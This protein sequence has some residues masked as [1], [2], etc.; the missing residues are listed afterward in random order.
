M[1][2][3]NLQ[4]WGFTALGEARST[5][6]R[7]AG[8]GDRFQVRGTLP[9][10][11]DGGPVL[12][13]DGQVT[14]VVTHGAEARKLAA[15]LPILNEARANLVADRLMTVREVSARERHLFGTATILSDAPE[16]HSARVTPL[17]SWHWPETTSEGPVPLSFAGPMGRYSVAL[18][19]RREAV[20][21]ETF[22]IRPGI[23]I[24]VTL[25][26]GATAG[27]GAPKTPWILGAVG[28]AGAG[29]AAFVLGGSGGGN[30]GP[31]PSQLGGITI[32]VPRWHP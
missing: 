7:L 31:P 19:F 32:S 26:I 4:A 2:R 15:F 22:E 1:A 24:Q 29:A 13:E 5:A 10:C 18:M 17:E 14:A 27:G 23:A 9:R 11:V 20:S 21:Q 25:T 6:V 30:G 3:A 16:G 8:A 28:A 12:D